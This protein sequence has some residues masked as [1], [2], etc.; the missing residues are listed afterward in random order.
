M[1]PSCS[2]VPKALTPSMT[3]ERPFASLKSR[4]QRCSKRSKIRKSSSTNSRMTLERR[5]ATYGNEPAKRALAILRSSCRINR[6]KNRGDSEPVS[7]S[8]PFLSEANPCRFRCGCGQALAPVENPFS[9]HPD[10]TDNQKT[11]KYA[12]F[13]QSEPAPLVIADRPGE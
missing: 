3:N 6:K 13:G 10:V 1:L 9:N 12:R 11:E 2:A 8:D 5:N 7:V 4:T